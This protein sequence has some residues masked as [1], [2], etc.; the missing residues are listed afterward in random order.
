[1]TYFSH[2]SAMLDDV[3][4]RSGLDPFFPYCTMWISVKLHE[5]AQCSTAFTSSSVVVYP[6]V[7]LWRLKSTITM[8]R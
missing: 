7:V 3:K 2:L 1:M 5:S 8:L 4:M 6:H